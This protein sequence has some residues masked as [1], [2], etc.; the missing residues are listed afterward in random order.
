[1]LLQTVWKDI[2]A[3]GWSLVNMDCTLEFEKPKFRPWREKVISSIASV[4]QVDESRVFVK[5]KTNEKL[6]SV[7]QGLAI[8]AYC[9]CLLQKV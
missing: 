7:G 2:C 4:L 6:D 9:T 5:A 3:K 8:K 1:M